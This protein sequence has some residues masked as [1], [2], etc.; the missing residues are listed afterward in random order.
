MSENE[1]AEDELSFEACLNELL[2]S[3]E[4]AT[5]NI[6]LLVRVVDLHIEYQSLSVFSLFCL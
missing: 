3:D 4:K 6:Q 5:L 2:K 1:F